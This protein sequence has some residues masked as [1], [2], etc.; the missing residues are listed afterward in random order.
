MVWD[1][2]ILNLHY[3]LRYWKTVFGVHQNVPYSLFRKV[4]SDTSTLTQNIP[5]MIPY[6]YIHIQ[7]YFFLLYAVHTRR[8]FRTIW[9]RFSWGEG[10]ERGLG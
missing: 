6:A 7:T 9:S 8:I 5:L 2:V 10:F 3:F 1:I 4:V